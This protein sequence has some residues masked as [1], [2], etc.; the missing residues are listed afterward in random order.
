M[1]AEEEDICWQKSPV[2]ATTW[3]SGH[4]DD[5][6]SMDHGLTVMSLQSNWFSDGGS[7]SAAANA[8]ILLLG[9]LANVVASIDQY[10]LA[11][12]YCSPHRVHE[13]SL[14]S[15]R[16]RDLLKMLKLQILERLNQPEC[17]NHTF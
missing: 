14:M 10:N 7:I 8:G 2:N 15:R 17:G 12:L 5:Q 1:F 13:K 4:I 9:K 16:N 11:A 3:V 6:K